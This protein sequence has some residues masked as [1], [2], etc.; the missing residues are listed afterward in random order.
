MN[1]AQAGTNTHT[2]KQMRTRERENVSCMCLSL[3]CRVLCS[4]SLH[5]LTMM[6]IHIM[7]NP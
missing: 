2:N 6:I 7:A 3:A 5:L 4:F 1:I